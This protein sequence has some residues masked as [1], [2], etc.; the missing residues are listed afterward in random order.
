MSKFKTVNTADTH[1]VATANDYMVNSSSNTRASN[2][3]NINTVSITNWGSDDSTIKL[4]LDGISS[5]PDHYITGSLGIPEGVTLVIDNPFSI[6]LLTHELK[7][8]NTGTT[9]R[10]TIRID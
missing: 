3:I 8:T 4:F 10:L 1:T 6:N 2:K 7:L 5:N 9:P